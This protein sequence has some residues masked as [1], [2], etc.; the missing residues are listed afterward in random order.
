MG[1][2]DDRDDVARGDSTMPVGAEPNERI[3][4]SVGLPGPGGIVRSMNASSLGL[5]KNPSESGPASEKYATAVC[6]SADTAMRSNGEPTSY[7]TG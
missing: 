5:R 7:A 1:R 2:V 4:R 6:A 3:V